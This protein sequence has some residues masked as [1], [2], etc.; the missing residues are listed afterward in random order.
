M[1][2]QQFFF[3]FMDFLEILFGQDVIACVTRNFLVKYREI[4]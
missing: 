3:D 4:V 2:T 1:A